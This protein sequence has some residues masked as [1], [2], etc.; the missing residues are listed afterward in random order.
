MVTDAAAAENLTPAQ[1][2][3]LA[4]A[5][6]AKAAL[7]SALDSATRA[8]LLGRLADSDAFQASLHTEAWGPQPVDDGARDMSASLELSAQLYRGLADA[9]KAVA[10][11]RPRRPVEDPALED[12]AGQLFADFAAAADNIERAAILDELYE[13]VEPIVG[14]QAAEVLAQLAYRFEG[15]GEAEPQQAPIGS[16]ATADDQTTQTGE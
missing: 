10:E 9:C 14:G 7:P 1:I 15:M 12:A 2:R 13:A 6:A 8:E 3:Y 16:E 11:G 4:C 5:D